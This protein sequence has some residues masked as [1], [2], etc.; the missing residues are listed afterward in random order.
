MR[1]FVSSSTYLLFILFFVISF[2]LLRR[3]Y[4]CIPFIYPT[5]PP[6]KDIPSAQAGFTVISFFC[7]WILLLFPSKVFIVYCV[8]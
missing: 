3:D 7:F 8:A 5:Y 4:V 1:V 6:H 2:L